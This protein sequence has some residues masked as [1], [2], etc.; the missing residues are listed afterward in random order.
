MFGASVTGAATDTAQVFITKLQ[1]ATALQQR[2]PFVSMTRVLL[3]K[4]FFLRWLPLVEG[5][6]CFGSIF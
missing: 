2:S 6:A 5:I 1:A 4:S 3:L